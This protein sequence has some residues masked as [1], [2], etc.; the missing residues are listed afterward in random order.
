MWAKV[1]AAL[2][3]L[4]EYLKENPGAASVLAGW[5][6]LAVAKLGL[7][8]TEAELAAIAAILV[9]LIAGGHHAARRAR[10]RDARA[11]ARRIDG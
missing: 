4:V 5:V 6:V 8:V 7:H 9:P 11:A 2:Q 10:E 3:A 1:R